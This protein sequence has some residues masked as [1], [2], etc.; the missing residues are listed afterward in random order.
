MPLVEMSAS[1]GFKYEGSRGI[2]LSCF[3]DAVHGNKLSHFVTGKCLVAVCVVVR[4]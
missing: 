3:C 2:L 4:W 1:V